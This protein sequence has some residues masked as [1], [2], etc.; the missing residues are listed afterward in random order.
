MDTSQKAKVAM[1][2]SS[3]KYHN[4][5]AKF[6]DLHSIE[7]FD[8]LTQRNEKVTAKYILICTGAR[9]ILPENISGS[10]EFGITTDDVFKL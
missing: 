10:A 2:E 5:I 9:P 1:E 8:P 7:L 3:I 4:N 6:N